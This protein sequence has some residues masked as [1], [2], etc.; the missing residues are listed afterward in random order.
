MTKDNLLLI[1]PPVIFE[2]DKKMAISDFKLLAEII[3]DVYELNF[4]DVPIEFI[5]K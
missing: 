1:F 4:E 5:N 3:K 2:T